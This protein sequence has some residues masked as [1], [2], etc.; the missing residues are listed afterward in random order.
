MP[1]RQ[2]TPYPDLNSVLSGFVADVR[3]A[4]AGNFVGAY[5]QG[6]FAV[7]DFDEHSDVDFLVV[8][9]QELT[10][11]QLSALQKMHG[12]IYDLEI[13]WA[14]HLEGSY[15]P[16]VI[17]NQAE[18]VNVQRLWYLDNTSKVLEPSI[19]DNTWVVRWVTREHGIPLAGPEAATLFDPVPGVALRNEVI[20]T[21]RTW[22]EQLLQ[23]PDQM[24]NRWYQ[25]FAVLSFCRML[26]T[27]ETGEIHSK[28]AGARWARSKL[29]SR[30]S[31]LIQRAWEDRPDPSTKVRLP[32]DQKELQE[33]LAFIQ[34]ARSAS[35]ER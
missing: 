14:K 23:D 20:E 19:H 3:V 33:T 15:F 18:A 35:S 24:N 22:G 4:L 32:A 21:M 12:R 29:D 10:D 2:P 34:E 25:P 31:G 1:D 13:G 16:R 17:L 26:H 11:D 9:E 5:L 27:L 30:W 8:T 7:G 6:S 28:L